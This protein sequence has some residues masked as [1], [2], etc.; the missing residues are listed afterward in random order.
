ML[1]NQNAGAEPQQDCTMSLRI[2]LL[3]AL[4][5]APL[6]P[7]VAQDRAPGTMAARAFILA[8]APL[9]FAIEPGDNT[10]ENMALAENLREQAAS[11][12]MTVQREGSTLV[13]RFD[14][15][16]R[17]AQ[18]PRRSFS[19]DAGSLDPDPGTQTPPGSGDEVTNMLTSRGGGVLGSRSN[20]GADYAR[21][22]KYVVNATLD[23]RTTGRRLWQGHVSYDSSSPDRTAMF[24]SLA[25]VLAEQIGKN[26][27]E[28]SFRLD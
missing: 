15:E 12:G 4:L 21:F 16:V 7:S 23:D 5:A 26:V 27:Q 8:P 14:T 28:R 25:P 6:V 2:L 1:A 24:V 22:L 9:A 18:A 13:L 11:R 3:L 10:D 19:R 17:T 20:S